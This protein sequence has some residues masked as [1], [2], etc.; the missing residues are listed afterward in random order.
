VETISKMV[1]DVPETTAVAQL[2]P[3]ALEFLEDISP[4]TE[5][6]AVVACNKVLYSL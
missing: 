2:I 1:T 4:A 5:M 6:G 3:F